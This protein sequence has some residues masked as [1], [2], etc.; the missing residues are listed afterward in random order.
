MR[1]KKSLGQHFLHDLSVLRGIVRAL[2][3]RDDERIVEIGPG[4]GKLSRALLDAVGPERLVCIERDRDMI[5]HLARKLPELDVRAGDAT[6][7]AFEELLD[8]PAAVCGNLPYNV[9]TE[10]YFHL[11]ERHRARFRRFVLMFQKEVAVRLVAAPGSKQYGPPSVTTT[12]LADARLV[13]TVKPGAFRPP[14]KVDSAV[15]AVDPLAAPRFDVAADEVEAFT[16]FVRSLFLQRRKTV[17]NNL[18]R[19]VGADRAA[20]ALAEAGIESRLR[21]EVL[22]CEQL[23]KL[24]RAVL[25]RS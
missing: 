4:T 25:T 18:K 5:D 19:V 22:S 23:V 3:P 8:G 7:F 6:G 9:G 2:D 13:M 20:A 21:P 17:A 10:I 24:W 14:P 16:K 15:I 11:L 1:A 12:L